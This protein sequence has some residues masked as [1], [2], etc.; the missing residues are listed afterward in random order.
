MGRLVVDSITPISG[1]RV[2]WCTVIGGLLLVELRTGVR[3]S[4]GS[5]SNS[6]KVRGVVVVV[7]LVVVGMEVVGM[8]LLLPALIMGRLWIDTDKFNKSN[9]K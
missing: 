8:T 9:W 2:E 5:L 4:E 3:L 6:S 7:V 1:E